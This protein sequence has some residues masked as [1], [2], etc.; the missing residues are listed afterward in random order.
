[1]W[2]RNGKTLEKKMSS[3]SASSILTL[4]FKHLLYGIAAHFIAATI[5]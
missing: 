2:E 3:P 1:M 5:N 4:L